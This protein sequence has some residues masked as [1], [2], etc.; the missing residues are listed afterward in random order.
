[1]EYEIFLEILNNHGS[2]VGSLVFAFYVF[3][4]HSKEFFNKLEDYRTKQLENEKKM[5]EYL[6]RIANK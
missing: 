5:L 3:G 1:M 4:R 2:V 6:E